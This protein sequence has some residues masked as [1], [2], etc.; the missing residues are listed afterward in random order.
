MPDLSDIPLT[1][2]LKI[3]QLPKAHWQA[4]LNLYLDSLSHGRKAQCETTLRALGVT[5]LVEKTADTLRAKM[6][7]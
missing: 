3:K 2:R 5:E 1:Q 6:Q 7:E 4:V